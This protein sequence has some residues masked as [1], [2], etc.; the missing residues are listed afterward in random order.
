MLVT[1][2]LPAVLPTLFNVM[3][4]AIP[5]VLSGT[6]VV[7]A[8]FNYPG[9]GAMAVESV[10]NHDYSL[11]LALILITSL[12]VVAAAQLSASAG[13]R[14][15]PRLKRSAGGGAYERRKASLSLSLYQG[16]RALRRG[17]RAYGCSVPLPWTPLRHV[18]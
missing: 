8:V 16:K 10:R 6:F 7:E 1:E 3:T 15:D 11:L 2:C 13:G 5:H 14:L 9:V 18:P 4:I 12:A 17:L